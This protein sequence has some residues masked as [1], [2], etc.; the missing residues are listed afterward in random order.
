MVLNLH[1]WGISSNQSLHIGIRV[2]NEQK[3]KSCH[4][5]REEASKDAMQH[6]QHLQ[7]SVQHSSALD[8]IIHSRLKISLSDTNHHP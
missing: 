3:L 7:F 1:M 2:D 4:F 6:G 5:E 8:H